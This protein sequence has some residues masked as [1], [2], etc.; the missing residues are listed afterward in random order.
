MVFSQRVSRF[1]KNSRLDPE[2]I[3]EGS[4]F[5]IDHFHIGTRFG[6]ENANPSVTLMDDFS[7]CVGPVRM[8]SFAPIWNRRG[9]Q[10]RKG[11]GQRKSTQTEIHTK[12]RLGFYFFDLGYIGM[13]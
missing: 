6:V 9:A 8:G 7:E 3:E 5:T 4:I 2:R 11:F 13:G 10:N 12:N 1:S